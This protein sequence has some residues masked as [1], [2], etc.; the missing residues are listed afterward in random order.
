MYDCART[1][2]LAYV[3][4]YMF[5]VVCCFFYGTVLKGPERH[6]MAPLCGMHG[7]N[8][9]ASVCVFMAMWHKVR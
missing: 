8:E 6:Y 5:N 3:I 7:M 1:C 9:G 4:L 2:V